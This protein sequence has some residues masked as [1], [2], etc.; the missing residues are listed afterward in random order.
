MKIEKQIEKNWK[1]LRQ[2]KHIKEEDDLKFVNDR[3]RHKKEQ[4]SSDFY[5]IKKL[6]KAGRLKILKNI[7]KQKNVPYEEKV[8]NFLP[9][10][11]GEREQKDIIDDETGEILTEEMK[12]I[13]EDKRNK[14]SKELTE[15][16]KELI[17]YP[18]LYDE[19]YNRGKTL[20]G[21]NQADIMNTYDV[22]N[23]Y[24]K[25][26]PV[27]KANTRTGFNISR[28]SVRHFGSI[29]DYDID[30][31]PLSH[32]KCK[33]TE[34]TYMSYDKKHIRNKHLISR[35]FL[36]KVLSTWCYTVGIRYKPHKEEINGMD[37][38]GK[39]IPLKTTDTRGEETIIY[40]EN[41][42]HL[43]AGDSILMIKDIIFLIRNKK[44][45]TLRDNMIMKKVSPQLYNV[46]VYKS[47]S[48]KKK[49]GYILNEMKHRLYYDYQINGTDIV[50]GYSKYHIDYLVGIIMELQS[51]KYLTE[52]MYP[53]INNLYQ[54]PI[55][56]KDTFVK[57]MTDKEH[58]K[59]ADDYYTSQ[60]YI[61]NGY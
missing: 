21:L 20:R 59:N 6:D 1:E 34:I 25:L 40:R 56:C 33:G 12:E 53:M 50:W 54:Y 43:S 16:E 37:L 14:K 3:H 8:K 36:S 10:K 7:K 2:Q 13:I 23:R 39:N 57:P 48:E 32:I 45:E 52:L 5:S 38:W 27:L 49:I 17:H 35:R 11:K 22:V 31:I 28:L 60:Y 4:K 47:I 18:Q 30:T 15:V 42:H 19:I 51:G 41:Q 26:K 46:L 55:K 44:L 58:E 9:I 61:D 24:G 29:G